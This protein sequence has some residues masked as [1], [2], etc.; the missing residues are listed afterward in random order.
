MNVIKIIGGSIIAITALFSYSEV[1]KFQ[2]KRIKQ[3]N[4]F[5]DL[6]DYI[7][8][9]VEC[10]LLPLDQ[11]LIKCDKELLNNC[12]IC[13]SHSNCKNMNEVIES[14]HFYCDDEVIEL[15]NKFS[16][17]FGKAYLHEQLRSCEYYKSELIKIRDKNQEKDTKNQ[18][19]QL[20]IFL[21]ASFSI[22]ILL[23]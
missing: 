14:T 8:N 15:L 1:I 11:I 17:S 20:A 4:G 23:I 10:F 6:I 7:K 2:K 16:Y 5:I 19:I 22:I 3:I 18:K 21:S 13:L 12:G 9:Q